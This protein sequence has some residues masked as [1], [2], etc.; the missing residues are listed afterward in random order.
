M[1]S[2]AICRPLQSLNPLYPCLIRRSLVILIIHLQVISRVLMLTFH[3][4]FLADFPLALNC[5]HLRLIL[6]QIIAVALWTLA[7]L[8][9]KP[10]W[11]RWTDNFQIFGRLVFGYIFCFSSWQAHKSVK[12][13]G[14]LLGKASFHLG[15]SVSV[16]NGQWA[17]EP[18]LTGPCWGLLLSIVSL[19]AWEPQ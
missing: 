13:S 12:R 16:S 11:R 9:A 1:S 14:T 5:I 4:L 10:G 2:F 18:V 8:P 17:L 19:S 15:C 7:T 3:T 6:P